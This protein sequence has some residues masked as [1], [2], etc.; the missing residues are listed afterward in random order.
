MKKIIQKLVNLFGY[1]IIKFR[2]TNATDLDGLTK[3]L[4][5][6]SLRILI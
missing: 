2:S 1:K 5:T 3:F 6:K 4:I